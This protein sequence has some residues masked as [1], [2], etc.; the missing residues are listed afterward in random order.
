MTLSSKL[1]YAVF[2]WCPI[3]LINDK[4]PPCHSPNPYI[5]PSHSARNFHQLR[6][7]QLFAYL[8]SCFWYHSLRLLFTSYRSFSF[9]F[10]LCVFGVLTSYE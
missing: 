6:V 4:K 5:F 3:I 7:L 9:F 10:F 1:L 8:W 2:T